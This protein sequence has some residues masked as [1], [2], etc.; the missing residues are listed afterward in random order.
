MPGKVK[1]RVLAARHLP[2][3]DR[4]SENTD[5]FAEVSDIVAVRTISGIFTI[6]I[7]FCP[8]SRSVS[9]TTLLSRRR[10]VASR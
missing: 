10:C 2:V 1:V 6:Y 3:M 5:A 9:A 7:M 4:S 8:I